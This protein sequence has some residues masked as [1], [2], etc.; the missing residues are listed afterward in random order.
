MSP[1][2]FWTCCVAIAALAFV[3][4]T[5]DAP[6]AGPATS[7]ASPTTAVSTTAAL[8]TPTIAAAT[9]SAAP[10]GPRDCGGN[11]TTK[12]AEKMTS[13]AL[14]KL[15]LVACTTVQIST[16]LADADVA[17]ALDICNLAATVAFSSGVSDISITSAS[18]AEI[19]H[20]TKRSGCTAAG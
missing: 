11:V 14:T 12:V 19:A 10:T 3:G 16:S 20:G 5:S 6:I 9:T 15:T 4:C 7:A 1:R 2:Q 8:P 13:H 18:G 17:A